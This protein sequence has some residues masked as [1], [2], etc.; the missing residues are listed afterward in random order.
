MGQLQSHSFLA[1]GHSKI[2][3]L[4]TKENCAMLAEVLVT[5]TVVQACYTHAFTAEKE[6]IMGI[7]LG[8]VAINSNGTKTARVWGCKNI[9]R[10]DKRPDRVEIAPEM[11][12]LATEEAERCGAATER[13]TRVIGWY[14]S[15]PHITPYPSHVDLRTQATFQQME[16]GWVG[17]IFSVFHSD[18]SHGGSSTLHCF[19]TREGAHEKVAV[20]VVPSSTILTHST[21]VA[22]QTVSLLKTFEAETQH[23]V[24]D[25]LKKGAVTCCSADFAELE[26]LCQSVAD[27]QLFTFAQLVANPTNNYLVNTVVPWLESRVHAL[28]ETTSESK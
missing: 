27:L 1:L 17:L 28:Q 6:E 12:F 16:S 22:E 2:I 8:D 7:L 15:H 26:R 19:Q 23:A 3:A 9:Q 20:T 14:H 18:A 25:A 24:E 11:L 13:H 4:S 5:D 21:I 10:V